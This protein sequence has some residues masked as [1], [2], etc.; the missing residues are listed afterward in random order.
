MLR[1][2]L[3]TV[4]G[5]NWRFKVRGLVH[6]RALQ[7]FGVLWGLQGLAAEHACVSGLGFRL[8]SGIAER[9]D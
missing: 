8:Y 6:F 3:R 1:T 9:F 2:R 5:R 7:N 4:G